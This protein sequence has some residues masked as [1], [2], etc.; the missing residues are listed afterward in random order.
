MAFRLRPRPRV[1]L[2]NLHP[3]ATGP[4]VH[5]VMCDMHHIMKSVYEE[6]DMSQVDKAE[7]CSNYEE[8]HERILDKDNKAGVV[9]YKSVGLVKDRKFSNQIVKRNVQF[10]LEETKVVGVNGFGL[11]LEGRVKFPIDLVPTNSDE[12]NM[13]LGVVLMLR[14]QTLVDGSRFED[15]V[16]HRSHK[17]LFDQ[18]KLNMR[19]CKCLGFLKDYNFDLSHHLGKA[20]VMIST[21]QENLGLGEP[22]RP[23]P[24]HHRT[25]Q[26]YRFSSHLKQ[27]NQQS[28]MGVQH[29]S[30]LAQL[31]RHSREAFSA[32]YARVE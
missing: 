12:S 19:Q 29:S 28:N 1:V 8:G 31:P 7:E 3:K 17:H 16:D 5:I 23:R 24:T 22:S 15:F 25:G 21:H 13:S 10:H 26:L 20:I 4:R 18:R 30:K 32:R 11:P 2:R 9:H 27:S 6:V 14:D